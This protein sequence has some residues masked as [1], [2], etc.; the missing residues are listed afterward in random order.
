MTATVF[1]SENAVL[2]GLIVSDTY[3]YSILSGK[4]Y[5]FI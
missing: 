1:K 2:I 3:C 4:N 5:I